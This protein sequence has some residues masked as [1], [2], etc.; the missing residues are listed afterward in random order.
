MAHPAS[1]Q[2]VTRSLSPG[3]KLPGFEAY[4][5]PISSAEVKNAWSYTYALHE[6]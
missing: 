5:S 6:S 4:R 3:A 2:C 1:I